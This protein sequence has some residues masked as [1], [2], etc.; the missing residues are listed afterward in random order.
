MDRTLIILGA[1]FGLLGTVAS[2]FAAHAAGAENLTIA[3]H[4]LLFH[5]PVLLAVPALIHTGL[6]RRLIAHVGGGLIF[7]GGALFSGELALR[8]LEDQSLFFMAAPIGGMILIAGWLI[9]AIAA[10]ATSRHAI[11]AH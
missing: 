6:V 10:L 2:G 4:F 5:A 11:T 3:A 1:L 8:A 7:I 9:I